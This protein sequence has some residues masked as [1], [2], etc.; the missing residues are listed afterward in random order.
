MPKITEKLGLIQ[1]EGYERYDIEVHNKNMAKI[2][3]ALVE[4]QESNGNNDNAA[5]SAEQVLE[6]S[7]QYTDKQ[8]ENLVGTAPE[9]LDTIHELASAVDENSDLVHTLHE[10]I[11]NSVKKEELESH[12][13]DAT[14]HVTS[15]ERTA[16]FDSNSKKHIHD[17][18]SILD[19][20]TQTLIAAWNDAVT[21]ITDGVKHVTSSDKELWNTVSRKADAS[22]VPTKT[23]DLENDSGYITSND[24]NTSQNH[25]HSNK[26]ILDTIVQNSLVSYSGSAPLEAGTASAGTAN[27]VSRSD[28]VHPA[29]TSISGNAGS[30]T[31]LATGRTVRTNLGSTSAVSFDGTQNITPGVSGILPIANGG[32]GANTAAGALSNLGLTVTAVELNKISDAVTHTTDTVKHIT[33]EER[34]LWNTVSGKADASSVPTKTS[35]LENDSGYI[36][37]SDIDNSQ[38]HFHSNQSVLDGIT[39]S[40]IDSWNNAVS[41]ISDTIK[42]ITSE[43]RTLWNTV[44][45]KADASHGTHVTYATTEPNAN[46]TASAG[47]AETVSRSDHVHPLQTSVSGSS[48]SCTGNAA[49]ATKATKDGNGNII[50]DTYA[51]INH[52]HDDA[53]TSESGYMSGADKTKLDATND[54]Y[55]TCTTA[56]ATAAKVVT[57][58][59]NTNWKLKAGSRIVVKFSETN[60]AENPTLN[61]NNTGA[62]SIWYNTALITTNSLSYAGYANRPM[63]FVYDGTQYIFIGWSLDNNTTYSNASLGQGYGTCST[64]AAT[65][66]KT[67]TL[68]SYSLT[69]GGVVAVKFTNAVPSSATMNINSKGAKPIYYRGAAITEGIIEAGDI[70]TFIYN[71]SQY[72]LL[73]V[74]RYVEKIKTAVFF[75]KD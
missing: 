29:Q 27:T 48:G 43:E 61:V 47:S 28:H 39:S 44:S 13:G 6:A 57:I 46:G 64:A 7:K 73:A 49:T 5:L 54:A 42:H 50:A 17:N 24:V 56:A 51:T 75:V 9:R 60:T 12:T 1:P 4:I 52:S 35:E 65:T 20:I 22:S 67:V 74:D 71:G 70:A 3:A 45:S 53:T 18:K 33:S 41:H 30:A 31:K 15:E 38:N 32:T 69:N 59:G 40:L 58:S 36:T 66:A 68:S 72:H 55:G 25:V 8:L 37:S 23:S 19:T 16:W 14:V 63:E 62:K 26:D 2:E 10:A 11:G 34:T 21:H